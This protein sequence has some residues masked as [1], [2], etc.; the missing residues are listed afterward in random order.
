MRAL[1]KPRDGYSSG[2]DNRI[3]DDKAD[4]SPIGD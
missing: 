1:G 4:N 2:S 3:D